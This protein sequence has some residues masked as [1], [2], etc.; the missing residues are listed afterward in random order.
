MGGGGG[1]GGGG[2]VICFHFARHR[3]AD[4]IMC[5]T[6]GGHFKRITTS[7]ACP[8]FDIPIEFQI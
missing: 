7:G 8:I 5:F 1:G 4:D 3:K 2:G 6:I